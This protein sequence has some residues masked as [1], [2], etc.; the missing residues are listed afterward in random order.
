MNDECPDI[1]DDGRVSAQ[2]DGLRNWVATI[3]QRDLEVRDHHGGLVEFAAGGKEPG[4]GGRSFHK[5][6]GLNHEVAHDRERG[7]LIVE[8]EVVRHALITTFP[9]DS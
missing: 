7:H 1:V 8:E 3:R 5:T 4:S 2:V 6:R 9:N